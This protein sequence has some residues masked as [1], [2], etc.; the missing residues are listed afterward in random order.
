[1]GPMKVTAGKQD[2]PQQKLLLLCRVCSEPVRPRCSTSNAEHA[3]RAGKGAHACMC[4]RMHTS[5]HVC[6]HTCVHVRAYVCAHVL[7]CM[8][9]H[10]SMH[11]CVHTSVA[12]ACVCACACTCVHACVCAQCVR[13]CMRPHLHVCTSRKITL[14]R[15]LEIK[16]TSR[17]S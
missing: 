1:M 15:L 4:V 2:E 8:R 11:V 6:V 17:V 7:V 9:V 10:M 16:I 13:V 12:C 3:L 14:I 5:T